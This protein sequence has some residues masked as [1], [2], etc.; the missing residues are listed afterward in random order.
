[1]SKFIKK[2]PFTLP[3]PCI[4]EERKRV[5]RIHAIDLARSLL[6][7]GVSGDAKIHVSHD[8]DEHGGNTVVTIVV[9]ENVGDDSNS[10]CFEEDER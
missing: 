3:G 1:M 6:T 4:T 8:S 2:K 5:V 7:G 9:R 10:F